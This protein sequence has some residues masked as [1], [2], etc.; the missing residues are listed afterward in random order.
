MVLDETQQLKSRYYPPHAAP[1]YTAAMVHTTA[2]VNTA[3]QVQTAAT[4]NTAAQVLTAAPVETIVMVPA[5]ATVKDVAPVETAATDPAAATVK[6]ASVKPSAPVHTL[7]PKEEQFD[8]SVGQFNSYMPEITRL[9]D[10]PNNIPITQAMADHPMVTT[11]VSV[12]PITSSSCL[13]HTQLA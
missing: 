2:A 10:I 3:A 1:A 13:I 12:L 11:S 9:L 5:A 7:E 4:V 8:A 6:T